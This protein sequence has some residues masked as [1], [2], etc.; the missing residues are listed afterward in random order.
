MLMPSYRDAFL[1]SEIVD[2]TL[3][4]GFYT[5]DIAHDVLY[6]DAAIAMLFGLDPVSTQHGLPLGE[7]LQRIHPDDRQKIA[8]AISDTV[9]AGVPQ[10]EYYRVLDLNDRYLP[11]ISHGRC[12]RDRHGDPI[13]YSGIII[14]A[15]D[16]QDDIEV[17]H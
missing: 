2:P 15:L 13:L 3:H 9:I 7:Y 6:G 16:T 4:A 5:W 12:F 1:A 14:P 11:V 17:A 8:R 10:Q